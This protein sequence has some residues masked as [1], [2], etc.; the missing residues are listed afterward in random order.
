MRFIYVEIILLTFNV[1][2]VVYLINSQVLLNI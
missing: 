1:I 2:M